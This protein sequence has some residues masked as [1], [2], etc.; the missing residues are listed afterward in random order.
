VIKE[1]EKPGKPK[2]DWKTAVRISPENGMW[3]TEIAIPWRE[4][5]RDVG[6]NRDAKISVQIKGYNRT[7]VGPGTFE[8]KYRGMLKHKMNAGAVALTLEPF[9]PRPEKR[10]SLVLHFAEL[11]Q[12]SPDERVFDVLVNARMVIEGLDIAEEAGGA[13]KALR[14]EIDNISASEYLDIE[15]VP[16][17]GSLPPVLSGL[18]LT[19][20]K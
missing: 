7:G 8:Y 13:H 11:E 15:F 9:E 1:P 2:S 12:V 5:G 6:S 20:K 3:I 18:E 17:K 19:K 10:Y 14:K 4:L 16:Q